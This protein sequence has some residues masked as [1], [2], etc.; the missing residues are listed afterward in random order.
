M[1]IAGLEDVLGA[2]L[3]AAVDG[4]AHTAVATNRPFNRA[5]SFKAM[6]AA[7]IDFLVANGDV[8]ILTGAGAPGTGKIT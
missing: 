8:I 6:A 1:P 7:I 5:D 2:A 4:V 3:Q